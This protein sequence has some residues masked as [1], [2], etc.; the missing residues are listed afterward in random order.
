MNTTDE[1]LVEVLSKLTTR[2]EAGRHFTETCWCYEELERRGWIVVNRPIHEPTKIPY[3][4]EYWTVE[5][6]E[7]GCREVDFYYG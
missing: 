3:S 6:T 7:E 2:N 4:Q 1:E 5:L